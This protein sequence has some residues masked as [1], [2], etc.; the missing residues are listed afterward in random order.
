[1]AVKP[2]S[3]EHRHSP[4]DTQRQRNAIISAKVA[5]NRS[6]ALADYARQVNRNLGIL[7]RGRRRAINL[8]QAD[9][10]ERVGVSRASIANIEA[11]EQTV[12]VAMLLRIA[13]GLD[14]PVE[15]FLERADP[16]AGGTSE[17]Q[18]EAPIEKKLRNDDERT[19]L[20]SLLLD[21]SHP[22]A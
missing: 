21:S 10:A 14:M 19:W 17:G 13:A 15:D 11:G 9:I 5:D 20:R 22:A 12:S 4:A 16:A 3:A 7:V 1:M 8:T 18:F 6:Q 2:L